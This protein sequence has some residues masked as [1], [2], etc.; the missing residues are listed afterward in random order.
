MSEIDLILE[1]VKCTLLTDIPLNSKVIVQA[2][3][4][5][6][7]YQ[8]NFLKRGMEKIMDCKNFDEALDKA[9][10]M[11]STVEANYKMALNTKP[12]DIN[13]FITETKKNRTS[14]NT[15]G[16]MVKSLPTFNKITGGMLPSDLVGIYGKEKSS[17]TTLTHEIAL[18]ICLEQKEPVA[19]FNFEMDVKQ[20]FLMKT[21][22]MR[23]G[24][25][26]NTLRNPKWES[27]SDEEFDRHSEKFN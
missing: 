5:Y 8:L 10:L 20:L 9:S 26:I 27:I 23:T 16:L 12:I 22:S 19:I 17:K 2:Q 21:F 18:D 11:I 1:G 24:I 4:L 15:N 6:D 7:D 14:E 13:H 3:K 25:S